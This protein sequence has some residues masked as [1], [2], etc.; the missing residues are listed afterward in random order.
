MDRTTFF[1]ILL[2]FFVTACKPEREP[3]PNNGGQD[4]D[5]TETVVKKYLVKVL[6]NDDPEKIRLAID[7]NEDCTRIYHVRYSPVGS[8]V[9]YDFKYYDNDSIS[10]IPSLPQ[11]SYPVWCFYYDS[12]IIHLK[13][14]QI[15]HI[16][17]YSRGKL[18]DVE[19]YYYNNNGKLV[20]RS[21]FED[22]A[23]DTFKWE[24]DNV[25]EYNIMSYGTAIIDSFTSYI[26]PYYN[27]PFYLSNEVAYEIQEPLFEPLWKYQPVQ[28]NCKEYEVD[29]EGYITKMIFYNY[30]STLVYSY[31]Y[32]Y[33]INNY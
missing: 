25:I 33:I 30:D 22:T 2:S 4:N 13:E 32:Y 7:W 10:V 1:L 23:T 19:H 8:V 14:T 24:G 16:C 15:D 26:H 31:N 18:D 27:L 11:N 17:C 21:Y 6:L 29:E 20:K 28:R 3:I 9:D 12:I 5:T